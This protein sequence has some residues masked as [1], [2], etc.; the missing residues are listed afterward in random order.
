MATTKQKTETALATR[1]SPKMQE[2]LAFAEE[3]SKSQIVPLAYA[4]RPSAI[5]AAIQYGKELGLSPMVSLQNIAVINGKPTLGSDMLMGLA[6]KHPEFAGYEIIE[7]TD[8]KATVKMYRTLSK[9][10]GK[11]VEFVSSFTIEDA[12]RAGL[13]DP[14]KP[15]SAWVRWLP[16]MLL[17]RAKAFA[18]RKAFPDAFMG[19]YSTEELDPERGAKEL[20]EEYQATDQ[21]QARVIKGEETK[22][23]DD[24]VIAPSVKKVS[25][26]KS[27]TKTKTQG[28]K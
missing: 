23:D 8:K 12:K 26:A 4:G 18:V 22:E 5:F 6:M 20:E 9:L 2:M 11:V 7:E 21:I 3:L 28:V 27:T 10:K 14:G 24:A 1:L 15:A 19:L 13:I 25:T 17:H 16:N